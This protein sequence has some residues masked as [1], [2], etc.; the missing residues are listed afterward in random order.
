MLMQAEKTG[1][2]LA[3]GGEPQTVALAA[4]RLAD[5]CDQP[6]LRRTVGEPPALGCG[7]WMFMV[8]R[9]KIKARLKPLEYFSP[10]DNVALL[11]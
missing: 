6:N 11:P 9:L 7:G 4:E 5:R 3:I 10:R 1:A 8:D 2:N